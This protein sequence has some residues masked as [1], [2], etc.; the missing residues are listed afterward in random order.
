MAERALVVRHSPR[1]RRW[2]DKC[3]ITAPNTKVA[4][5]ANPDLPE[6]NRKAAMRRQ[7]YGKIIFNKLEF[8]ALVVFLLAQS[9]SLGSLRDDNGILTDNAYRMG[10]LEPWIDENFVR[11][12]WYN[13]GEQVNVKM[14]RDKFSG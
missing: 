4:M 2:V 13:M 9:L 3:Q 1:M 6:G 12:V 11:T 14:I 8:Y 7:H 5:E 10:E